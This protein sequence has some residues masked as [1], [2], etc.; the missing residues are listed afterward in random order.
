LNRLCAALSTFPNTRV[1]EFA[2][3]LQQGMIAACQPKRPGTYECEKLK[4][5]SSMKRA[6]FAPLLM[7]SM[8]FLALSCASPNVNQSA[9]PPAPPPANKPVKVTITYDDGTPEQFRIDVDDGVRIKKNLDTIKWRVKYV[10]PGSAQAAE[11]TID[12]FRF[13]SETNPFG[14]GSA[15]KNKFRFD[16]SPNGPDKTADTEAASKPGDFKYKISVK[17]PNG[18]V[19]IVDPVVIIDN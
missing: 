12:D 19:L 18:K 1:K 3:E 7:M 15:A 2:S 6:S 16:P 8:T 14:D 9:T 17:L 11:V 4:E 5:E 10:G 13:G